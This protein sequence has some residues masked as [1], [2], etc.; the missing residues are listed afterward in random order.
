MATIDYANLVLKD[1][2]GNVGIV[3]TLNEAS[4]QKLK[5]NIAQTNTNKDDIAAL[6]TR[7]TKI[8]TVDGNVIEAT[9]DV[10]GAV[11][12]ATDSDIT[13][14][15]TKKVV[16]AAQ[17]AAVKGD[18]SK[19][20]KFKGSVA[21]YEEL[22]ISGV[23]NGDVYNVETAHAGVAAGA[24]YAAIVDSDGS[25]EWDNLAGILDVSDF[26]TKSGDNAFTG[27]NTVITPTESSANEQIANKGYVDSSIAAANAGVIHYSAT[28]PVI[29]DLENNTSTF[30]A[31]TDLLA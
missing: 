8:V 26:A 9:P 15:D 4:I 2:N 17:L 21:T 3:R 16:T 20:Y 19:V 31:A 24:N 12:L 18:L 23:Q 5:D 14:A 11:K 6:D 22:P 1:K 10:L 7:L 28:E 13:A 30:Y 27:T 29:D 25:I